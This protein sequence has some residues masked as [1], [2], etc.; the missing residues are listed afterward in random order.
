MH[1]HDLPRDKPVDNTPRRAGDALRRPTHPTPR[2]D[3]PAH[4]RV[5]E[6]VHKAERA[7]IARAVGKAEVRTG[8]AT[9]R[10]ADHPLS[11]ADLPG[12]HSRRETPEIQMVDGVISDRIASADRA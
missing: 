6:P 12:S 5:A 10:R 9:R 11:P 1:H 8:I 4:G 7:R 3:G 2:V